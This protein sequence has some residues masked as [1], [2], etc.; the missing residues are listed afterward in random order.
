[1]A[2]DT[3]TP[4]SLHQI[5]CSCPLETFAQCALCSRSDAVETFATHTARVAALFQSVGAASNQLALRYFQSV[6]GCK[7]FEALSP[8]N[9]N[10]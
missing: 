2:L 1:M 8:P 7:P 9:P 4:P 3:N 5:L 10:M 6:A